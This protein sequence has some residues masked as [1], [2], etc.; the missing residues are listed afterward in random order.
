MGRSEQARSCA[1]ALIQGEEEEAM[2]VVVVER[3]KDIEAM[4]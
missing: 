1:F 3:L 4:A 2:V